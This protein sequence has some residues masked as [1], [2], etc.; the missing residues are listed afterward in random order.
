M[1]GVQIDALLDIWATSL[2]KMGSRVLFSRNGSTCISDHKDLYHAI[3]YIELG[4]VKWDNFI[5]QYTSDRPANGAPP[6]M[7][8]KYEVYFRKP[9]KM[10]QNILGNPDF[11]REM[12]YSPYHK[13]ISATN[14]HQWCDFMSGDWAWNQAVCHYVISCQ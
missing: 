7:D 12:D 14:E 11:S 6:W 1:P 10:V 13:F 9:H 2:I 4:D 3:D 5:V 8:D